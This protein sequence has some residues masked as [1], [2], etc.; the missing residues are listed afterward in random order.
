MSANGD[1][2]VER[3][4]EL[5]FSQYEAKTYIGL[6][7][8][9]EP[10]TGYALANTTNVPQPKIYETLRRL[11]DRGNAVQVSEDPAR[12]VAVAPDRLFSD[13]ESKFHSRI[14][15]AR[16]ELERLHAPE[17]AETPA[18]AWTLDTRETVFARAAD[19]LS[20]AT[21][22]VYLSGKS[23]DL[24]KLGSV[25]QDA[26]DRG[27]EFV[28]LHF[29]RPPFKLANAR[30]MA[31]ASTDG[32]LYRRRRDGHLAVVVDSTSGLWALAPDG[33][34]WTG[35][36]MDNALFASSLKSYMRHDIYL[37]RIFVDFGDQLRH[38]YGLGLEGL[39]DLIR[40]RD[41]ASDDDTL[42]ATGS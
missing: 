36:H 3:L 29:G 14:A 23:A 40:D 21:S 31:H 41:S 22:R 6:L 2:A 19:M 35:V 28:I 26:S 39:T 20:K 12:Y 33:E 11:V 13:M 16:S 1:D 9:S 25:A 34:N 8:S 38:Q 37:Q 42:S 17:G 30:M 32:V 5:S 4:T 7:R 27:V 10:Q 15:L 24:A 18:P